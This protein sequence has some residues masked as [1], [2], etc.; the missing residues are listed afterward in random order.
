[1]P[2]QPK[3]VIIELLEFDAHGI[4][5]VE[6]RY[7]GETQSRRAI[8]MEHYRNMRDRSGYELIPPVV[9]DRIAELA[10]MS[11]GVFEKKE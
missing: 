6:F 3:D 9:V 7:L 11:A 4:R 10:A 8:G 1:M 5:Y 2:K